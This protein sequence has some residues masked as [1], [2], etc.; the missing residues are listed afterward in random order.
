MRVEIETIPHSEQR[1]ETVGDW[2]W[3]GDTLHMRVSAMGDWKKE[4]CVAYHELREALTCKEAG[5][6]QEDV[7]AFDVQF[8]KE[9][10]D[11]GWSLDLEAGDDPRAPYRLQHYAA[12][13]DERGLAA[14]LN[15]DWEEYN[16]AVMSL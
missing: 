4:M 14:D 1:Y 10:E 7:D 15:L 8:E 6:T 5:I 16:D 3:E 11:K 2:W 12:T 13:H 9:R